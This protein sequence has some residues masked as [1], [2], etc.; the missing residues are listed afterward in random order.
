MSM[1]RPS[2]IVL[3][4]PTLSKKS[5]PAGAFTMP[6]EACD[7][8]CKTFEL[9]F[10]PLTIQLPD[11]RN[12]LQ[13]YGQNGR[14]DAQQDNVVLHFS[15]ISNSS[16][17]ASV[18][19]N[20]PLY[21]IYD[22]TKNPTQY[23]FS[24]NN[25]PTSLWIE[26][27]SQGSEGIIQVK[28][29]NEN[30]S[31][32]QEPAQYAQFRLPEKELIRNNGRTWELGKWRVDGSLLARQKARWVG[33]DKFLERHGGEEFQM[34][35]SKHRIDF[36]DDE[37]NTYS[38]YVGPNDC[39]VWMNNQWREVRPGED[40]R[41][42][43]LMV[44][45]KIDERLMNFELWDTGGKSKIVLNLLKISENWTANNLQEN[46]KFVGARRRSQY[47]FEVD[48]ERIFLSPKDWLLQTEEGWVKLSTVEQID[49]YV[50]RKLT[51]VLFVF[52]GAEKQDDQ[53]VLRG[54]M[55]NANR[56]DSQ[57]VA[58]PLQKGK[59]QTMIAQ[60]AAKNARKTPRPQDN[61][62]EDDDEE[63]D[64]DEIAQRPS[65]NIPKTS[66]SILSPGKGR[67][68]KVAALDSE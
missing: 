12:Q 13:Y 11:L 36:T 61:D 35:Q 48:G 45:K 30:G 20:D 14:P 65:V 31:I 58:V 59:P 41:N 24:P 5:L 19:A 52:E 4:D 42:H 63:D 8:I 57:E 29:R 27:S 3:T 53:Q 38:V 51:G 26:A 64:E 21:L 1:M 67:T 15:F 66:P 28:L 32:I 55:F 18:A 40:S 6:K 34:L 60:Q 37:E 47:I 54:V 22:N 39:L 49:D 2:E 7:A 33:V 44:V 9:K 62:D 25:A 68:S 43:P 17:T 50:N 16:N 23:L 46:F 56:T 10:S